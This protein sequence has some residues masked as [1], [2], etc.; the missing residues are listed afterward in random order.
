MP[1]KIVDQPASLKEK[2]EKAI[3]ECS[4]QLLRILVDF[5]RSQISTYEELADKTINKGCQTVIPEF[6]TSIPDIGEKI[7]VAIQELIDNT[8]LPAEQLEN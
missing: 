7:E 6:V 4:S 2:W 1:L 5:H 3:K 8:G